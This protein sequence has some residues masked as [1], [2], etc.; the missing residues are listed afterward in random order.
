MVHKEQPDLIMA[1][2]PMQDDIVFPKDLG[3][4]YST[5][6]FSMYIHVHMY[7]YVCIYIYIY[8]YS[9]YMY[10]YYPGVY[11]FILYLQY[12]F[13]VCLNMLVLPQG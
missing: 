9:M 10:V 1:S 6:Y 2:A 12:D 4:S 11:V 13:W 3:I 5:Y 7:D 8:I